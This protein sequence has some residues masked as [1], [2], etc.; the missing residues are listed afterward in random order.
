MLTTTDLELILPRKPRFTPQE[1]A[2]YLEVSRA[3]IYRWIE[4]GELDAIRTGKRLIKIS[5]Q[6]ILSKESLCE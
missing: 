3:T 2:K 6:A 4:V 5:R 1:A